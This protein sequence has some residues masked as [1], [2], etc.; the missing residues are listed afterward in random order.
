MKIAILGATGQNG[1]CAVKQA[2][3]MGHTVIAVVR[4]P[5]KMTITHDNLKVGVEPFT[6]KNDQT[7]ILGC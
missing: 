6:I 1:I 5:S 7:R 4:N 2:L 3:D